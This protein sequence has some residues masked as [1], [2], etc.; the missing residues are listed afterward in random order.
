[1][2][3]S[4]RTAT[5]AEYLN[6]VMSVSSGLPC[7]CK[8]PLFSAEYRVDLDFCLDQRQLA[9]EAREARHSQVVSDESNSGD[10]AKPRNT[11]PIP[12]AH[13]GVGLFDGAFSFSIPLLVAPS[14]V[15]EATQGADMCGSKNYS[16]VVSVQQNALKCLASQFVIFPL[17]N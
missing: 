4:I 13:H 11:S 16:S 14:A 15:K 1:M 3:K 10:G 6:M 5:D 17:H 8:T 9:R 2:C 7:S 12:N